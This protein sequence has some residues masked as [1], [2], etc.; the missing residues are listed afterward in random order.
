MPR[1]VVEGALQALETAARGGWT[2]SKHKVANI[3]HIMDKTRY[4]PWDTALVPKLEERA[5]VVAGTFNAQDVANT[6]CAYATNGAGALGGGDAG[7]GGAGGGVGGHVPAQN[8]ANTL[9]AYAMMGREPGAGMM[10]AGGAGGG[11]PWPGLRASMPSCCLSYIRS[12]CGE[13]RLG[14]EAINDSSL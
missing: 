4:R 14:V 7:A 12:L 3:L 8:V 2:H 13:T 9:W 10:R 6:L 11:C 5:E 1:G